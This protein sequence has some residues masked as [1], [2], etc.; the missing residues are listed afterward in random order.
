MEHKRVKVTKCSSKL[1]LVKCVKECA[2]KT[3]YE[4]K[5]IVDQIVPS[6][7]SH[8]EPGVLLLNESSITP[9]QWEHIADD[10]NALSA[11]L[12]PDPRRGSLEWEYV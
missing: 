1:L 7:S 8:Q 11:L 10:Y 12:P 2:R 9:E 6:P 4:A 3:L 5:C